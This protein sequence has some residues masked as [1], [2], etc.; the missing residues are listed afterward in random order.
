M[1]WEVSGKLSSDT[2]ISPKWKIPL[3]LTL[4][5]SIGGAGFLLK[6][7]ADTSKL[8][9]AAALHQALK[10]EVSDSSGILALLRERNA[11]LL[12]QVKG[13]RPETV[14]VRLPGLPG[15]TVRDTVT[16]LD[17]AFVSVV[18]TVEIVREV[19]D[20]VIQIARGKPSRVPWIVTGAVL[21]IA[22]WRELTRDGKP[23]RS[24]D[25]Q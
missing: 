14:V 23:E 16:L 22:A 11:I 21:G 10:A 5:L 13:F 19:S 8:K 25:D 2:K 17:T 4:G 18:E 3:M 12:D 6:A 20:T 24:Y 1:K 9:T 15:R 7:Q